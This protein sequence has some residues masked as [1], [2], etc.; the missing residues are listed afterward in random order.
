MGENRGKVVTLK[1]IDDSLPDM[2]LYIFDD[3]FKCNEELIAPI[4]EWN[5]QGKIMAQVENSL[6]VWKFTEKEIAPEVKEATG[7]NGELYEAADPYFFDK[8]GKSIAK[9]KKEI[10]ME[11]PRRT[12]NPKVGEIPQEYYKCLKK[13]EKPTKEIENQVAPKSV[14]EKSEG[15]EELEQ[16]PTNINSSAVLNTVTISSNGKDSIKFIY[17]DNTSL[18]FVNSEGDTDSFKVKDVVSF[19]KDNF[20]K[21][22][23]NQKDKLIF[24]N[25]ATVLYNKCT[26]EEAEVT[27]K[28]GLDLPSMSLFKSIQENYPEGWDRMFIE[29]VVN[30]IEI[31]DLKNKLID[32]LFRQYNCSNI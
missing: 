28:I 25:E 13:E 30:N 4:N 26:K 12:I 20:E 16:A 22:E 2:I 18:D 29:N 5:T 27:L 17:N 3:G 14:E 8:N 24:E 19:L 31:E 21:D 9:T 10:K 1:E 23:S 32:S 11:H 15:N 7:K 6:N